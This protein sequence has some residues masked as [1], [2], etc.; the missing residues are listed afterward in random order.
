MA[1]E[2]LYQHKVIEE[3]G[4]QIQNYDIAGK[5]E[6]ANRLREQLTLLEVCFFHFFWVLC[7]YQIS[8]VV[9]LPRSKNSTIS[10]ISSNGSDH[11]QI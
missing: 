1:D 2:F 5:K 10:K 7:K 3:M 9:L 4:E 11:R 8:L 6:A